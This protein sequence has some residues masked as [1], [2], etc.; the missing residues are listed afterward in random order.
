MSS[1]DV[2]VI[3]GGPAGLAAAISAHKEGAHVCLIEREPV[4]G[5]ILKQCIHDG[6]GLVQ[7]GEK[8]SGPEYA[9]RFI[10]EF[11]ELGIEARTSNFVTEIT[12][13]DTFT[14]KL[15]SSSG[16][17]TVEAKSIVL[18]T[19]CRERTARQVSIHGTRPAGIFTAGSAQ[20]YINLLGQQVARKVVILGSGDIGLIM[21][22]RLTLEGAEVLG[23]YEVLPVPSGLAR[24][25]HQCLEDF[26]IP[27]HLS[28]T[29]TNVYGTERVEAVDVARVDENLKPV[30]GT[31]QHIECDTLIVSVGLIPENELAE[32]IGVEIDGRTRGPSCDMNYQTSVPGVFSCGNS[33]HVYDLVDYVTDSGIAA[34]AAAA[35]YA[36]GTLEASEHQDV[37][38]PAKKPITPGTMVCIGCPKGCEMTVELV[39][40]EI[41]VSGNSCPKGEAFAIAEQTNPT[42]VLCTSVKT[43]FRGTPVLPVRTSAEIPKGMLFEAMKVINACTVDRPVKVGDI[44]ISNILGT[45]AD[46]IATANCKGE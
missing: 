45:G 34:G 22:R 3:G 2:I 33:F 40:S 9:D 28:T 10:R 43:A 4:L 21:A 25:I 20:N 36:K 16:I 35:A 31:E 26:D 41:R 37:V 32:S 14:L 12:H 1:Y 23:V 15:V 44:I 39:G 17:D 18:A 7:F 11:E 6:F 5:G 19:G 30:P 29:V 38:I 42:R 13:N 8:L 24:N 46:V 27:L